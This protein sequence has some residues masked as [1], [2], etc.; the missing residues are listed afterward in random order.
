METEVDESEELIRS[1]SA[2]DQD[3]IE[4]LLLGNLPRLRAYIR[5]RMGPELCAKES[6]SDLV[7]STCREI[8]SNL[9]RFQYRGGSNFR[10][11]LFATALRKVQNRVQFYRSDRRDHAREVLGNLPSDEAL[12]AY[13][14]TLSTPS[15]HVIL[16]EQVRQLEA[17]MAQLSDEHR[18]VI[19]LARVVELSHKEV[20]EVMGRS[21]TASRSLLRRALAELAG[22]MEDS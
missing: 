20:S 14:Q 18:E 19:L 21:E 15:Q 22:H 17:A 12:A 1:A 4:E 8:L 7:Q 10:Q 6:A 9:E 13:Y 5:F 3:A 11:W 16:S 2:G